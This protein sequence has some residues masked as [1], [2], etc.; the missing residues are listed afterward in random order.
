[1]AVAAALSGALYVLGEAPELGWT[2]P[3]VL[4]VAT[5]AV[6][7]SIVFI[8][9]EY[10]TRNPLLDLRLFAEPIFRYSNIATTLQTI[11]WLGGLYYLTPLLL[12]EVGGQSPLVAGAVLS[13]IP[14]GVILTTQ[15]VARGFDRIGPRKLVVVGQVGLATTLLVL[16]TFTG[17]TPVWAFCLV[18]FLAGVANGLS[19]VS[20][21]AAMFAA[22]G[23]GSLSQAATVL[24]VNRQ[25]STALGVGIAT[26]IITSGTSGNPTSPG[27]YQIAFLVTAGFS[28][29]A[30]IIG[31]ALPRRIVPAIAVPAPG[32]LNLA[33]SPIA[34]PG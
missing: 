1:M 17:R 28:I 3:R 20:L 13:C 2:N 9:V 5:V 27:T 33:G 16:A 15:T 30:A 11:A 12:Q 14:V 6:I 23:A 31:L 25:F 21:Q 8:N 32:Q 24:N 19:M 26:A 10:R 22:I 7:A 18:L 34:I 29:G 4:A